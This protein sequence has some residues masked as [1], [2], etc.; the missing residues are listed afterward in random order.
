MLQRIPIRSDSRAGAAN[1][2]SPMTTFPELS[3]AD[4]AALLCSKLCHDIISPVFGIQSGLEFL[5]EMPNDTESRDLVRSSLN[6]AVAKLQFARIAFGAAGSPT[7]AVDLTDARKAA[8]GY[9]AHEKA[10]LVW[11][12]AVG[13]ANKHFVKVILNLIALANASVSRGGQVRVSVESIEPSRAVVEATGQRVRLQPRF[14]QLLEGME[15]ESA[16]DAQ[17][18][19]PYYV[20]FLA[21]EAGLTVNFEQTETSIVFRI[22]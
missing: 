17:A 4:L 18:I 20:L 8:E 5:E 1:S 22:G 6:S 13:P 16:I 10:E 21:R 7:A 9:M 15:P 3:S 11:D 14:K 2:K 12:G 19:Q